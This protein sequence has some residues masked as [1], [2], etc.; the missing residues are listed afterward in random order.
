MFVKQQ[1]KARLTARVISAGLSP[2]L[3]IAIFS[4]RSLVVWHTRGSSEF[5]EKFTL[6]CANLQKHKQNEWD[7]HGIKWKLKPI[8]L[9][10]RE[11]DWSRM[12]PVIVYGIVTR[13][14]QSAIGQFFL[15]SLVTVPELNRKN[16]LNAEVH[17]TRK[18][19]WLVPLA[20]S[21]IKQML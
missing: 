15:I 18:Y 13:A 8:R 21:L 11:G 19:N 10:K 4:S 5:R 17:A 6:S 12:R 3:L 1:N 2:I 16:C 14:R 9:C 20:G 7:I